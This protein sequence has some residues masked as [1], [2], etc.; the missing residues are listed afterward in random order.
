MYLCDFHREQSWCRW[1]STSHNGLSK[2]QE[3]VLSL[4]RPIAS[5]YTIEEYHESL[6]K[7]QVYHFFTFR[8][9]YRKWVKILI[10]R[11]IVN[12]CN[13]GKKINERATFLSYLR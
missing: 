1:L 9:K 10:E 4:L 5:A 6:A 11:H 2:D 8:T 12:A 3:A 13:H 7:L